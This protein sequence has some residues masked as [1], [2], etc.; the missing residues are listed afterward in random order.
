MK[1][2][3]SN[4]KENQAAIGE[5]CNHTDRTS[6][7]SLVSCIFDIWNYLFLNLQIA[8]IQTCES[9]LAKRKIRKKAAICETSK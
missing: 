9:K 5:S 6:T 7:R 4:S 3:I 1:A 8:S 2:E